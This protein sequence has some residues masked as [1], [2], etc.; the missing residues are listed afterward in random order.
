[1]L[2]TIRKRNGEIVPFYPEKI[3]WAIFKAATAVG[4]DDWSRAEALSRQ[5]VA[6]AEDRFA[7]RCV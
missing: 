5:V 1:M 6:L 7:E 3:T 4:G 2:E